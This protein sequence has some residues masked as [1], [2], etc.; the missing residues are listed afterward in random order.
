MK[1]IFTA[2]PTNG[3]LIFDNRVDLESY[4]LENEGEDMIVDMKPVSKTSAKMRMY[5]F[6]FGPIMACASRGYTFAGYEGMDN[7][8]ARYKLQ[9]EF[10]KEE[11]MGPNGIETYLIDLSGM[12]KKRLHKFI[13]DCLH[14]LETELHQ[15]VPNSQEYLAMK[16]NDG[17]VPVTNTTN[18]I[19]IECDGCGMPTD[20]K[21]IFASYDKGLKQTVSLCIQCSDGTKF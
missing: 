2:T 14:F 1:A 20:E 12:T 5:A 3:R 6:L 4:C 10:A 11:M 16:M 9:A 17:F 8:K 18:L 19:T 7:V 21:D 13:T 15:K